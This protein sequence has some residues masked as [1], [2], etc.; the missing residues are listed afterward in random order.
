METSGHEIS[1]NMAFTFYPCLIFPWSPWIVEPDLGQERFMIDDP[2]TLFRAG[3]F[4]RV[5]VM[6]GI[7]DLEFASPTSTWAEFLKN[8]CQY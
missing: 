3:N 8:V 1:Q 7:T 2:S 6:A 5:N 4:S